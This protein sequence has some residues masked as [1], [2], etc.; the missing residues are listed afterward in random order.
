MDRLIERRLVIGARNRRGA[1]M[2]E[3]AITLPIFMGL[4][5]LFIFMAFMWNAKTTLDSAV[6]NGVRLA[7]TRGDVGLVGHEL[8]RDIENYSASG[9]MSKRLTGM[10]SS[11]AEGPYAD[12][13]YKSM[14][15][16]IFGRSFERLPQ[17]YIYAMVYTMR[18]LTAGMGGALMRFPCDTR[19]TTR[20]SQGCVMCRFINPSTKT[21]RRGAPQMGSPGFDWNYLGLK[22]SYRPAGIIVN[23]IQGIMKLLLPGTNFDPLLL[24]SRSSFYVP[25]IVDKP[26]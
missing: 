15:L 9:T 21:D 16:E 22:C 13:Y 23:P 3:L 25:E 24:Q 18:G 4:I 17:R 2:I 26:L 5:F 19:P 10:L 1:T 11:K 20:A 14:S 6:S 12:V 7:F 8:I